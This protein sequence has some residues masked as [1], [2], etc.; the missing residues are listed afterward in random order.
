MKIT[1]TDHSHTTAIRAYQDALDNA[2]RRVH[3]LRSKEWNKNKSEG[4]RTKSDEEKKNRTMEK[5][6]TTL[7]KKQ[8][9]RIKS[10]W[11]FPNT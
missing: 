11:R 5:K 3:A 9:A 4:K 7:K 8:A 6:T 1:I 10:N 2:L